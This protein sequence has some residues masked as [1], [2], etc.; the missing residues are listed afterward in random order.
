M[1]LSEKL[2]KR[3]LNKEIIDAFYKFAIEQLGYDSRESAADYLE[4]QFAISKFVDRDGRSG[5]EIEVIADIADDKDKAF[6][7]VLTAVVHKYDED[8]FFVTDN[9]SHIAYVFDKKMDGSN[10]E[11]VEEEVNAD[12]N[13]FRP[14]EKPAKERPLN[15]G[16]GAGYKIECKGYRVGNADKGAVKVSDFGENAKKLEFDCRVVGTVDSIHAS[17][18][19]YG[20]DIEDSDSPELRSFEIDAIMTIV[21]NDIY[22]NEDEAFQAALDELGDSEIVY[23]GGWSHSTYDGTILEYEDLSRFY[24][25]E[26][27]GA[28]MFSGHLTN[29]ETIDFIDKAVQGENIDVLYTIEVDGAE[30]WDSG[31]CDS[32]ADLDDEMRAV[33]EDI[34]TEEPDAE[35]KSFRYEEF[36]D[37][38]GEPIHNFDTYKAELHTYSLDEDG[39]L[40]V[41]FLDFGKKSL[42]DKIK[43]NLGNQ[44]LS[45]GVNVL[46]GNNDMLSGD[47][48]GLHN[49]K[50]LGG[51][52]DAD[53]VDESA[54]INELFG[55]N[56]KNKNDKSKTYQEMLNIIQDTR[57]GDIKVGDR[58]YR[59]GLENDDSTLLTVRD[60]EMKGA[61][62]HLE[63]EDYFTHKTSTETAYGSSIFNV[64]PKNDFPKFVSLFKKYYENDVDESVNEEGL[65]EFLDFGKKSIADE[66]EIDLGNQPLANGAN[67]LNGNQKTL[68]G[69]MNG[70]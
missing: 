67:I 25:P 27:F 13:D 38:N 33:A 11:D 35:V 12:K 26:N 22:E 46:N 69:D 62:F 7:D 32:D 42:V 50:G 63:Y 18:Y 15:E 64:I 31:W 49:M 70:L 44:P 23:G 2:N 61:G 51:A 60:I 34:L 55:K 59:Q 16:P 8:A 6:D 24:D 21:P 65:D 28:T 58:I 40:L 52:A 9:E 47:M 5:V 20:A 37:I 19:Y 14:D 4:P 45:N 66:I 30:E 10:I 48:N 56:K 36:Y 29:Q 54:E 43:I 39:K 3:Q 17:S 1:E 41:E 57:V 68:S 53:A